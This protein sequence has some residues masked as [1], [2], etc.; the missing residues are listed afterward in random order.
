MQ[1]IMIGAQSGEKLY[2]FKY[3]DGGEA[4]YTLKQLL[5][6]ADPR[7]DAV[8]TKRACAGRVR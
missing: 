5:V 6:F 8:A 7:V 4:D 1:D 2:D 3:E